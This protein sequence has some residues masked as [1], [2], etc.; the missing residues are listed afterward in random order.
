MSAGQEGQLAL[1]ESDDGVQPA[2][3]AAAAALKGLIRAEDGQD[4]GPVDGVGHMKGPVT[5][6]GSVAGSVDAALYRLADPVGEGVT[7]QPGA[8]ARLGTKVDVVA[9]G[10]EQGLAASGGSTKLARWRRLHGE[11]QEERAVVQAACVKHV[12]F[13]VPT[14]PN[15][16]SDLSGRKAAFAD[17]LESSTGNKKRFLG[18]QDLVLTFDSISAESFEWR[19]AGVV[20][21]ACKKVCGEWK[22]RQI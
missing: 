16:G 14:P 12:Q 2:V 21:P 13:G 3:A 18:D 4:Q 22:L 1:L 19:G 11:E 15:S 8:D 17:I 20:L 5:E 10:G 7:A 6:G 9:G